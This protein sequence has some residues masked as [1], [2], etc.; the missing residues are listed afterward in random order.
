MNN[1]LMYNKELD[2]KIIETG[3][4]VLELILSN[5]CPDEELPIGI[6]IEEM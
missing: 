3:S 1:W 6:I 4:Y 2:D 5:I